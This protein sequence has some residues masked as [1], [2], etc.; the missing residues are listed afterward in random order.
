MVNTFAD[1][2]KCQIT[3]IKSITSK[4]RSNCTSY[5]EQQS[6]RKIFSAKKK[7]IVFKLITNE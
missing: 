4:I 2:S 1:S 6:L 5:V 3:A 7:Q